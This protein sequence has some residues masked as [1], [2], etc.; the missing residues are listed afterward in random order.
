MLH[1]RKAVEGSRFDVGKLKYGKARLTNDLWK[2]IGHHI[3]ELQFAG[4]VFEGD[5][6]KCDDAD[7]NSHIRIS[8]TV[9]CLF[10]QSIGVEQRPEQSMGIKQAIHKDRNSSSEILKSSAIEND[11]LLA[12]KPTM[13]CGLPS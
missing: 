2:V 12:N 10:T 9:C 11:P 1:A 3:V 13:R 8:D 7:L 5:F 6:P 4:S